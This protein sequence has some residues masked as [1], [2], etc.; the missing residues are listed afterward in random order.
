MHV[1]R[2]P[3]LFLVLACFWL[4]LSGY[5]KPLLL[6]L[7]VVSCL[8]VAWVT[9]RKRLIDDESALTQL[10]WGRWYRYN[11]WLVVQIA[12][13]AVDVAARILHPRLPISPT[14]D[15]VPAELTD[16]G[17]VIYANS[18]TLTPGTVSINLTK[19]E[20]IVHSLT[21]E[22]MEELKSGGMYRR[23]KQLEK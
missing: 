19:D 6:T 2:V 20:I 21:R 4:A 11:A 8:L 12:R 17:K 1:S 23:V 13:S 9:V 10:R 14:V 18:I 5:F 22:G 15:N 7:G 3:L 16:L